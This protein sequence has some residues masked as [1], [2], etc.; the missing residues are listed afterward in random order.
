MS[1]PIDYLRECFEVDSEREALIW[2]ERPLAHF[3]NMGRW[4]A[5]N[6]RNA[7]DKAGTPH[8]DGYEQVGISYRGKKSHLS[9]KRVVYA[10]RNGS[11]PQK[12]LNKRSENTPQ[13]GVLGVRFAKTRDYNYWQSFIQVEENTLLKQFPY[14]DEGLQEAIAQRKAWE[15]EYEGKANKAIQKPKPKPLSERPKSGVRGVTYHRLWGQSILE[16]AT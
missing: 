1:I 8:K 7:G 12:A 14:T 9:V 11:W 4:R 6:S 10:I 16:S 5:F 3:S 2:R 15:K 13:S